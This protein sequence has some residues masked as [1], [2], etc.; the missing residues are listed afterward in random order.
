MRTWGQRGADLPVKID[1]VTPVEQSS[2]TT[3]SPE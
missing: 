1:L 3:A 2:A